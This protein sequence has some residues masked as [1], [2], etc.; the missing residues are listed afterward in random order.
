MTICLVLFLWACGN[1]AWLEHVLEK[2][3]N[4]QNLQNFL[5]LGYGMNKKSYSFPFEGKLLPKTK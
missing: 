1:T 4:L 3:K 5:P 2:K